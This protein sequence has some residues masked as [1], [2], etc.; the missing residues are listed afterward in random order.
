[1][2]IPEL[3]GMGLIRQPQTLQEYVRRKQLK[4]EAERAA[5][6]SVEGIFKTIREEGGHAIH[7]PQPR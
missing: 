3:V 4:E 2:N 5:S 6:E 1:M 7:N